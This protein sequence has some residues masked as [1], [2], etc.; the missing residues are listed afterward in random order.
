L[1]AFLKPR[2]EQT[3]RG[4]FPTKSMAGIRREARKKV[5]L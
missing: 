2:I 5:G 1:A 4:A 3:R